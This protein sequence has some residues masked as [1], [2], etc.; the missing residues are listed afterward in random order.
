MRFVLIGPC[1][2]FRGGIAQYT[3]SLYRTLS[4]NHQVKLISFSRQYPAWLFPGRAQTDRSQQP[5]AVP[6]EFILDSISPW[7]WRL[8][9][10]RVAAFAPDAVLF[11]WW[12]PFFGP[13]YRGVMSGIKKRCRSSSFLLCHNLYSHE[14]KRLPLLRSV[15]AALMRGPISRADGF[16]V[17]SERLATQIR[18]VRSGVPV[19][20]MYHPV[21]DFY[22]SWDQGREHVGSASGEPPTVLFFGKI[23]HYKGLDVFL[24]SLALVRRKMPL[25]AIIAGEF[26]LN[27]EPF[28]ERAKRLAL[29]DILEWKTEY[30]PNEAI[31]GLFRKA[32]LVVLPY[33]QATQSGVVP[34]AYQFEVPV[35]VTRVGG[36]EEVVV[37]GKTGYLVPAE[38]P[39]ALAEAVERFFREN[40]KAEFQAHIREFR[41]KLSWQQVEEKLLR[42]LHLARKHEG[43]ESR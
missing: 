34:L 16:L 17:H 6:A 33:R 14:V 20:K 42:L 39:P 9:A 22:Q 3:N 41:R 7:S 38:D 12:H 25:R 30:I 19:V 18:A 11:Q 2:P 10:E 35:V 24:E 36:L 31:P 1:Y 37:E 40:K 26:Y 15:E 27:Q 4:G 5:F 13:A 21:Y 8:T 43:V 29:T 32:D 23:R 28:L